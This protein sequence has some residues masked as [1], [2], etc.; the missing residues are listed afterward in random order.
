[1]RAVFDGEGDAPAL[2]AGDELRDFRILM[3][4]SLD[5]LWDLCRAPYDPAQPAASERACEAARS[6]A[7]IPRV[8]GVSP[9]ADEARRPGESEDVHAVRLL[10]G[11]GFD[12][13]D[14]GFG[15]AGEKVAITR[16]R[17]ELG[18]VGRA[19]AKRQPDIGSRG[20]VAAGGE[21]AAD[22]FY[23]LPPGNVAWVTLGR[24]LELGAAA[25]LDREHWLR[26][27]GALK[28][29]NLFL[30][31]S[32]DPLQVSLLPVVG[33]AVVPTAWGSA[34][35][36]PSLIV[37]GGWNLS[38]A[39]G[40]DCSGSSG[41]TIGGCSRPEVEGGV[42]LT[43]AGVVRVQVMVE[44]YPPALAAPGLWTLAPSLGFQLG[45]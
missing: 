18:K 1:M 13:R 21:L 19:L 15:R 17:H 32:S 11:Y 9:L 26:L 20:I 44:W 41:T 29:Q 38:F 34:F 33:A 4:V 27:G 37:R 42:G 12:W 5:R 36:Q 2:C 23:Y 3:Q 8:P 40:A 24:A 16:L 7:P 25:S 30:A 31:L 28:V 35:F 43:F 10:A 6:G 22:A 39:N 45:F 14:M